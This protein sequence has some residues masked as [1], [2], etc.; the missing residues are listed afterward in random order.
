MWKFVLISRYLQSAATVGFFFKNYI[1][2]KF[3][4]TRNFIAL[5][6]LVLFLATFLTYLIF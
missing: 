3:L 4:K 5:Y 6:I 1:F 2:W